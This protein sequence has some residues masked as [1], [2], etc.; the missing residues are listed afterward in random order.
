MFAFKIFHSLWLY[1]I[2]VP[3]GWRERL[4]AAVAATALTH[5]IAR[6]MLKGLYTSNA[7]FFRTPKAE[8]K[9]ALVRAVLAAR[10]ES[11]ILVGLWI[12]ALGVA[13]RYG[14]SYA[15]TQL[16]VAVLLVQSLPYAASLYLSLLNA[17]PVARPVVVAAPQVQPR[18]TAP[19]LASDAIDAP[20]RQAA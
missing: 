3:G 10:E 8:D 2:R 12:G 1:R 16:W 15:E 14:I 13:E 9:P 4:G 5:S 17:R 18:T 7:P 20:D 19:A 6:A 11:L